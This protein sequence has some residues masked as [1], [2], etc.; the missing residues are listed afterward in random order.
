MVR[1]APLAG[2]T[3]DR[4]AA[5][6]DER[7]VTLHDQRVLVIGGSSG[8]GLAT[9]E[10]A[11]TE[12]AAVTIAASDHGRLNTALATLPSSCEAFAVDVRSESDLRRL[13][14]HVGQLDHLVYTAGDALT[15]KPLNELTLEEARQQ[16]EVRF[17]GAVAAVK[18]AAPQIRAGGSIVLSSGTVGARPRPGIGFAASGVGAI[19]ALTRGLAV[20]LAPTR[21]NAVAAGFIRTAMWNPIPEPERAAL[22]TH[23]AG[24]TLTKSIGEADDIASTHLYLMKNRFVTG[25][26]LTVDGGGVLT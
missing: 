16:F 4:D 15:F 12:G 22:F 13:F 23:L 2:G 18:L 21:V 19:E 6:F 10:A 9:A 14:A 26:I 1:P 7:T 17:W 25:T 8:M 11:A 3:G 24:Q 20:E 5:D